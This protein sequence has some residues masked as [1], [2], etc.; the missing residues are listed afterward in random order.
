[1]INY[2]NYIILRVTQLKGQMPGDHSSPGI[3]HPRG[4]LIPGNH[5]SPRIT[6]PRG[7]LIPGDHS[8]PGIT[9]PRGFTIT[10]WLYLLF[11]S[12]EE[13]QHKL[14][15]LQVQVK[16]FLKPQRGV[17]TRTRAGLREESSNTIN[18]SC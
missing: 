13:I 12:F 1:M 8:S 10:G 11:V 5:S 18:N 16:R 9:H 14:W 7:S 2:I 15:Q 4:S 6:H 3:T 17:G